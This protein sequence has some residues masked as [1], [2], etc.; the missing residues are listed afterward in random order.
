MNREIYLKEVAKLDFEI[1]GI[2]LILSLDE[3]APNRW[4]LLC[5]PLIFR[6]PEPVELQRRTD[7]RH[8]RIYQKASANVEASP[9]RAG[10]GFLGR[11]HAGAAGE[12]ATGLT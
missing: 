6:D 2:Q 12:I 8:F 4:A 10:R 5:V 7:Q 3:A 11:R 9:A 1:L